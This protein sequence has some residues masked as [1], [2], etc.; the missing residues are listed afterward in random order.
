MGRLLAALL[1]ACLLCACDAGPRQPGFNGTD[2]TGADY[3]KD[4]S[5]TDTQGRRR[6]L[7]DF[8]GRAVAVFFGYTQCPDVCPTTLSQM[9]AVMELLGDDADR[10][11]VV[12]ITVDPERD[13]PALLADYVPM[14][15]ARFIALYGSVAE[16]RQ[17]TRDFRVFYRKSGDVSANRYTVDHSAG[18]YLFDP[19]GRLRLFF[20]HGEA[21]ER[22]AADVR[23]LLAGD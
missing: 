7:A 5:L 2:I 22:I 11:Q 8:A 18:L 6:N 17:V 12:F 9:A 19:S 1:A 23:R 20:R 4:F 3:A 14:F 10:L 16:T 15:D 21:P 13:T